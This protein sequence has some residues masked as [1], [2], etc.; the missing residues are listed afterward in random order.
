M[1]RRLGKFLSTHLSMYNYQNHFLR[2]VHLN[3]LSLKC[4]HIDGLYFLDFLSTC[5]LIMFWFIIMQALIHFECIQ[6][7]PRQTDYLESLVDKFIVPNSDSSNTA[8]A[9]ER[10]ELSCI[11]L[12]VIDFEVQIFFRSTPG[13]Y[14]IAQ[15]QISRSRVFNIM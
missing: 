7:P 1:Q 9:A 12:E 13:L 6:S 15:K 2:F 4:T 11:F 5:S 8:S 3:S 14:T 10:E